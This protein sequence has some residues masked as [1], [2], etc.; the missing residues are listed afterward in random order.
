MA[1]TIPTRAAVVEKLEQAAMKLSR[2]VRGLLGIAEEEIREVAGST[3][4]ACLQRAES[5][6]R[7]ALD[8]LRALPEGNKERE[9]AAFKAGWDWCKEMSPEGEWQPIETAP[10]DGTP[11]LGFIS[12]YYR[13]KGGQS[14]ILWMDGQWFDNLAF[15]T[16]PTHWMP[17]PAPPKEQP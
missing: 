10:K 14:V 1:M 4:V 9:K 7:A 15:A 17:L 3:N 13:N 6:V 11:I 8:L 2:E 12:S 16:E 5:D